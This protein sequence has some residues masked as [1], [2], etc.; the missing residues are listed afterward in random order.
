M[1]VAAGLAGNGDLLVI[2]SGWSN[3]YA[4]GREGRAFRA[5]ILDPWICRSG[6]GARSWT[7]DKTTFPARGPRGGRCIPFGD[8]V[9]G[10][11][12]RLRV[13]IYEVLDRRDDRVFLFHSADDGRTW[14]HPVALDAGQFRNETALLHLGDGKWLAAARIS[15]LQ[16]YASTDDGQT[17]QSR[18]AVTQASQHPGHLLRLADGRLLLSYGNRTADRG[19]DVRFSQNEG[20]TWS[21]P[22]RV[23]DFQRDGGFPASVQLPDGQIL[24]AFYAQ[25]TS[26][27]DRYHMGVVRWSADPEHLPPR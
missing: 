24:T 11:D 4:P 7:V 18:G 14:D 17:W 9:A 21:Q 13:A 20:A 1:N 12:G 10:H 25:T 23:S 27:C 26:Q 8:I 16:L 19:V 2:A 22:Y 6:D 3:R 5:E 15:E